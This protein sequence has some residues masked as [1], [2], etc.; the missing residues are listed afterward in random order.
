MVPVPPPAILQRGNEAPPTTG[1]SL[2]AGVYYSIPEDGGRSL[3]E[4]GRFGNSKGN[5]RG[6]AAESESS[7]EGEEKGGGEGEGGRVKEEEEILGKVTEVVKAI[8]D[9]SNRV[10]LS[11]PEQYV[12]LVKVS[13]YHM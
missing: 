12:E 5:G 9:L 3:G 10:S 13:A 7:H 2:S 1:P 8:M 6:S 4:D 11:S